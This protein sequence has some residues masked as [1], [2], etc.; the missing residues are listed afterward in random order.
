MFNITNKK[1][2]TSMIS[3]ARRI[4]SSL[5]LNVNKSKNKI[6]ITNT[7]KNKQLKHDTDTYNYDNVNYVIN[8]VQLN[9]NKKYAFVICGVGDFICIDYFL[10]FKDIHFIFVSKSSLL[11]KSLSMKTEKYNKSNIRHFAVYF[12]FDILNRPGFNDTNEMFERLPYLK[13]LNKISQI[14]VVDINLFKHIRQNIINC[15]PKIEALNK[16]NR[17][18]KTTYCD[19]KKKF[20]LPENIMLIC[21][22]TQDNRVQCILCDKMHTETNN[23][24]ATR[25]FTIK[26]YYNTES[27]LKSNKMI[28]VIVTDVESILPDEI[29]DSFI[30]L[31]G[32]TSIEESI[33]ILKACHGY[34]GIDSF[35]SIIATKIFDNNNVIIKCYNKHAYN[36]KDIYWHPFKPQ[37]TISENSYLDINNIN[38]NMSNEITIKTVQGVGDVFWV[39]QKLYNHFDVINLI[40]CVVDLN[41]PVQK[42][43]LPFLKLLP[44]VNNFKLELVSS[45]YYDKLAKIKKT[46]P[47]LLNEWSH[48]NKH[49]I[50]YAVNKWLEDGVRID[51]I[52][53]YSIL[54]NVYLINKHVDIP[55]NTKEYITLYIS[56]NKISQEWQPE[57]YSKLIHNTFLKNNIKYP[58]ILLGAEYDKKHLVIAGN[59][60]IKYGYEIYYLIDKPFEKVIYIIKNSKYFIGYQSGL[61][62]LADNYDV[63]QT[64]LYFNFLGDVMYSWPKQ[65]NIDSNIYNAFKF[66]EDIELINNFDII[67]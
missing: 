61:S 50:E 35:L 14:N 65:K 49:V 8:Y 11:L 39:Y 19:V 51:Q 6:T 45:K 41:C 7:Q 5:T 38:R 22:Y 28:G 21:P 57:R 47:E 9:K 18:L 58:I 52:D 42:R 24:I 37:L 67:K 66:N 27:I 36:W 29:K 30:N 25:N 63:P 2:N 64:M 56:G 26:D 34:I 44:K 10:N 33:E 20:N 60:L 13:I 59:E 31:S 54:D 17:F 32:K 16:N 46:I 55:Y 4:I 23:C 43:V 53:S 3:N 12:N 15:N 62:I 40:I 1:I 48:N